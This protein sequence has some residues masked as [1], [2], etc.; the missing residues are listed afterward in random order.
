MTV[1]DYGLNV[2][3][4]SAHEEMPPIFFR[5]SIPES[6][7]LSLM[8]TPIRAVTLAVESKPGIIDSRTRLLD[9]K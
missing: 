7:A 3:V 2:T 1:K 9:F 6:L 5:L 8:A 4:W